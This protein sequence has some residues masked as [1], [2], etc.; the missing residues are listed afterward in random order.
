MHPVASPLV[1]ERVAMLRMFVGRIRGLKM[2]VRTGP[3]GTR[4]GI[5]SRVK[6]RVRLRASGTVRQVVGGGP[7]PDG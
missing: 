5:Q 2:G 3:K 4:A 1:N 7:G 6:V